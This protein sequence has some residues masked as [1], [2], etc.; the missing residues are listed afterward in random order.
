MSEHLDS[1]TR[2]LIPEMAL[3]GGVGVELPAM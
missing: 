2:E 3:G 1:G